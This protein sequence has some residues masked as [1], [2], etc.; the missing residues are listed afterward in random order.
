MKKGW[1]KGFSFHSNPLSENCNALQSLFYSDVFMI[2]NFMSFNMNF[3]SYNNYFMLRKWSE[4][5]EEVQFYFLNISK[6]SENATRTM[7][8]SVKNILFF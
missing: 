3:N 1:K 7:G 2:L 6:Q 4:T 5:K 8:A